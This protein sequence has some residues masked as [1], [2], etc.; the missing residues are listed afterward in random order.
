MS[1]TTYLTTREIEIGRIWRDPH[2]DSR[3]FVK[4]E[5]VARLAKRVATCREPGIVYVVELRAARQFEAPPGAEFL[6]V[7]GW[8]LLEASRSL[9]RRTVEAR[10]LPPSSERELR[11]LNLREALRLRALSTYERAHALQMLVASCSMTIE[12]VAEL[13]ADDG[14]SK[15]TVANALVQWAGLNPVLLDA[16]RDGHRLLTHRER[17]RLS[18]LDGAE[19]LLEWQRMQ[20]RDIADKVGHQL[21]S[22]DPQTPAAASSEVRRRKRQRPMRLRSHGY[23]RDLLQRLRSEPTGY[24]A[25][26][27]KCVI[28]IIE[29]LCFEAEKPEKV[30]F[31]PRTKRGRPKS[32]P[33]TSSAAKARP[34]ARGA[35]G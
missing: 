17:D 16:W 19:Q 2:L 28:E 23:T 20:E 7:A 9:G 3:I 21:A 6:L 32:N 11:V 31:E 24:T 15:S 25:G 33:P 14:C 8:D 1:A 30:P 4:P 26:E 27:L 5:L 18:R 10:V 35:D 29:H 34:S 13:L 22:D 12:Q